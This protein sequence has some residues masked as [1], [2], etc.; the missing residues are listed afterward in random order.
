M[1]A[2]VLLPAPH[3]TPTLPSGTE[4]S[5]IQR[6]RAARLRPTMARI[7]VL[8]CIEAAADCIS[9]DEVFRQ[10]SDRGAK[11]S[12]STVY[13]VIHDME[14][15][16]VV[17]REWDDRGT[18]MYR[19]RHTRKSARLRLLCAECGYGFN[20]VDAGLHARLLAAA[21]RAGMEPAD[22]VLT[23][24]LDLGGCHNHGNS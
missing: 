4:S 16:N 9:A 8:Q 17:Q 22:P 15:A 19:L 5:T 1:T 23:V 14:Q 11:A 12:I 20:L 10:V 24:R 7:A 6:L 3:N 18:A 21:R 13:R 2:P